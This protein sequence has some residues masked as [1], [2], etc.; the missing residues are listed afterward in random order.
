MYTCSNPKSAFLALLLLQFAFFTIPL[1]AQEHTPHKPAAAAHKFTLA[2]GHA[3][4]HEGIENDEKKWLMMAAWSLN[5]DYMFNSKWSLGL[6]NDVIFEDFSVEEHLADQDETILEREKPLATK[7]VGS[8]KTGKHVSI[9]L[10]IGD[11]IT[12]SENLFLSTAGIEYGWHIGDSWEIGAEL[13]YDLK[14]KSY[15]TWILGFG[16]SKMLPAKRHKKHS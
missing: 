16:I 1:S 10:G 2:M 4:I 7:L 14:W 11:E 13:C 5:Y 3:H 8:F 15:D 9:M 12:K 6:H